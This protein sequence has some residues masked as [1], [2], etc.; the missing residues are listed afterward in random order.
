MFHTLCQ[1]SWMFLS[2]FHQDHLYINQLHSRLFLDGRWTCF[3]GWGYDD[4]MMFGRCGTYDALQDMTLWRSFDWILCLEVGEHVPKQCAVRT[5]AA[6]GG[7]RWIP[8]ITG[9]AQPVEGVKGSFF[10][11]SWCLVTVRIQKIWPPNF[12]SWWWKRVICSIP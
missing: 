10:S 8:E 11:L 12:M 6:A 7:W 3:F 1:K 2:I 4:G 9:K 5:M